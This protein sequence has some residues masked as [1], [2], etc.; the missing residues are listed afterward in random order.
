MYPV[1]IAYD[2]PKGPALESAR[3]QLILLAQMNRIGLVFQGTNVDKGP[4]AHW[5]KSS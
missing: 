5:C 1:E 3:R 4:C 2:G